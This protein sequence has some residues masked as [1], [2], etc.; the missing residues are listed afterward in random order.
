MTVAPLRATDLAPVP[1]RVV[2]SRRWRRP[3][4]GIWATYTVVAILAFFSLI[5]SRTALDETAFELRELNQQ[6]A[7]E[8]DTEQQ[9]GL[10]AARLASPNEIVPAAEAMGLVLPDNVIP[11]AA[12]GVLV[13]RDVDTESRVAGSVTD[14]SA[15]P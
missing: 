6:I 13:Q 11:I 2:R 5:Y 4:M 14:L 12:E 7:V 8:L 1:L 9:L 15:S 10:E 3:Q